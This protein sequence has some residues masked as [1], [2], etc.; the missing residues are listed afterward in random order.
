MSLHRFITLKTYS[1]S[2]N[3][4]IDKIH[5]L[6]LTCFFAVNTAP[7]LYTLKRVAIMSETAEN[8]HIIIMNKSCDLLTSV[9]SDDFECP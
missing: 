7:C 6:L 9:I 8:K 4:A 5:L 2:F 3:V 1:W